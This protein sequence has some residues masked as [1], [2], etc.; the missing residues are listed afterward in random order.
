MAALAGAMASQIIQDYSRGQDVHR[1]QPSLDRHNFA[2][3][4]GGDNHENNRDPESLT[5]GDRAVGE[6]ELQKDL[7]MRD[8]TQYLQDYK[9]QYGDSEEAAIDWARISNVGLIGGLLGATFSTLIYNKNERS[10]SYFFWGLM[11]GGLAASFLMYVVLLVKQLRAEADT[12]Y[13]KEMAEKK[14]A[15]RRKVKQNNYAITPT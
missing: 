14:A 3:H 2:S 1:R 10:K 12:G 9:R 4:Q 13:E 6:E 8:L 15:L 5:G 11:L 7:G